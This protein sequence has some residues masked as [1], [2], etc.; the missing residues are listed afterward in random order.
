MLRVTGFC[1]VPESTYAA[2]VYLKSKD[3]KAEVHLALIAVK[4]KV[5]P[6]K[7]QTIPLQELCGALILARLLHQCA[8]VLKIHGIR[9]CVDR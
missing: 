1:D 8:T 2:V 4:T 9:L 7:C 3:K 6:V 5:A